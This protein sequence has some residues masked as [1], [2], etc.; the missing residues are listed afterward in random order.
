MA[1]AAVQDAVNFGLSATLVKA[2]DQTFVEFESKADSYGEKECCKPEPVSKEDLYMFMNSVMSEVNYQLKW[3]KE[4]ISW[5]NKAF[6]EHQKGH[7]PAVVDVGKM[8]K[9]IDALGLG[10]SYKVEKMS[11]YVSY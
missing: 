3:V 1:E 9:V 6:N 2:D 7:I 4:D 5:L 8:Q 11:V 10:D